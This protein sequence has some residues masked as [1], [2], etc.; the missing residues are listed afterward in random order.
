MK[1]R[2][3]EIDLE[4]AYWQRERLKLT[5]PLRQLF[6]ECTLK[7]NM[8]CRHCGSDCRV[9]TS[10]PDM[11]FEEFEPV[12]DEVRA[13]QPGVQVMV[14]TVG[15]EPL[16][17]PDILD[18]GAKI[19]G[20]GFIWGMVSNGK[21]IEASM[22]RELT[23]AGLRSLSVDIDGLEPEHN[24]LR[25]DHKAF[26]AAFNAIGHIRKAHGLTWDVI[27]C[28]HKRNIDSLNEVK[29]L[30]VEAGV[31]RWRCFTIAPMGRAQGQDSL[32]LSG[33]EL[34]RLMDFIVETRREGKIRLDYSCEG[35]LGDYEGEV[36]N[37]IFTCV[38]GLTVASVLADGGISGCLSIRSQYRQ[39]N[40]HTDSFW[41]VWQH[42]FEPYRNR[43]WMKRGVCAHCDMFRYC[44][45][46]GFH[47]RN[48]KGD[49]ALCHYRRL[50]GQD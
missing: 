25:R 36:R 26:D 5:H 15:G 40:I 4:V 9:E 19:S 32:V 39:G 12:L 38:A 44:E 13:R 33:E 41:D 3:K 1:D 16:V 20:K 10:V 34:R 43:G 46:S 35:F 29:R 28:V 50:N 48:D 24:W 17:R 11:P 7:C 49:L 22:V 6:W 23:R 31:G 14:N 2:L 18:C 30:L 42:R 37:H 45:G 21:L 8:A 47:L 27:T